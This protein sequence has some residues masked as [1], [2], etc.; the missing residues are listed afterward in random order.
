MPVFLQ[1]ELELREGPALTALAERSPELVTD[2]ADELR[3]TGF[4]P[5][6]AE[7][8]IRSVL[9]VE[10]VARDTALGA[11]SLYAEGPNAFDSAAVSIASMLAVHLGLALQQLRTVRNLQAGM[12]NR[13]VIGEAIGVLME[14]HKLTSQRAYQLLVQASQRNNVKLSVVAQILSET[15]QEPSALRT[16]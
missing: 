14:R 16:R 11:L 13:G 15:G 10:L 7:L 3:W 8:G 6:V 2:T 4:A 5:A 12:S 1:R 9:S